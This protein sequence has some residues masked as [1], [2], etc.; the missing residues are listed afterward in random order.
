MGRLV[1]CFEVSDNKLTPIFIPATITL[2]NLN[3]V[4]DESLRKTIELLYI[5]FAEHE[6]VESMEHYH[7]MLPRLGYFNSL[8]QGKQILMAMAYMSMHIK[9]L[10]KEYVLSCYDVATVRMRIEDTYDSKT[11]WLA[12]LLKDWE[13]TILYSNL[14]HFSPRHLAQAFLHDCMEFWYTYETNKRDG[15]TVMSGRDPVTCL[16]EATRTHLL[17]QGSWYARHDANEDVLKNTILNCAGQ[18]RK[19]M[20]FKICDWV[21]DQ[22]EPVEA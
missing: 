10:V 2:D 20:T 16:I 8:P 21:R 14:E 18:M 19:C 7:E 17:R 11:R 3:D 6:R 12:S 4:F 22:L 9:T 5:L 13:G 15:V 1:P